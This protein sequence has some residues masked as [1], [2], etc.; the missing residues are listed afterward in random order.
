MLRHRIWAGPETL[1]NKTNFSM[2]SNT[3]K[4][5]VINK[6]NAETLPVLLVFLPYLFCKTDL[7][8]NLQFL[9]QRAACFGI[10]DPGKLIDCTTCSMQ[11]SM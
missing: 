9:I 10:P 8:L 6:M 4:L 11:L 2:N 3:H 1:Q 7:N 5:E